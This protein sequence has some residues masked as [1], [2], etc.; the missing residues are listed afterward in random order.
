[1]A[2]IPIRNSSKTNPIYKAG[3]C[4]PPG[5]TLVFDECELPGYRQNNPK[6]EI[7]APPN[8]LTEFLGQKVQQIIS[9]IGEFTDDELAMLEQAENDG[10]A[11]KGV[12]EAI[13]VERLGRA[14]ASQEAE[15]FAVSLSEME[16]EELLKQSDLVADDEGLKALVEA[17]IAR[18]SI[19]GN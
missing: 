13:A 9:V 8:P 19:P 11:R 5:E 1:M 4:I 14:N 2:Q 10:K 6:A 7:K 18:R 15:E 17:E 3:R 12:I 16:D